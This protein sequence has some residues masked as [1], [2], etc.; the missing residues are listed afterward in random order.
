MPMNCQTI[1]C[2]YFNVVLVLKVQ[3]KYEHRCRLTCIRSHACEL[4]TQL[5]KCTS[6]RLRSIKCKPCM[7]YT[8]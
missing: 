8:S 2:C 3:L 5:S 4:H 6:C 1:R 7:S